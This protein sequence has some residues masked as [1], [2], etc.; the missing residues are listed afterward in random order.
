MIVKQSATVEASADM[1]VLKTYSAQKTTPTNWTRH[2]DIT[3]TGPN[4]WLVS[5][6]K[7]AQAILRSP[8]A[9]QGGFEVDKLEETGQ[10]INTPVLFATGEEHRDQRSKIARF[11]TPATVK[12]NYRP[13]MERV[14]Q[15]LIDDVKTQPTVNL[16]DM[17]M[18]MAVAIAAEV[19]GLTES[20]PDKMKRRI[21]AFTHKPSVP[22]LLQ[23]WEYKLSTYISHLQLAKFYFGD[24]RPAIK[25]RKQSPQADVITHLVEEGYSDV[26]IITEC[27]T[28]AAAGM[29]TTRE[30]LCAAIWHCLEND[31][32]RAIML[33]DDV[34]ARHKLLHEMLRL[35]PVVGQLARRLTTPLQL[36]TKEGE[37]TLPAGAHINIDVY[38]ANSD[39]CTVGAK[40]MALCPQRDIDKMTD[41]V[42]SFGEGAHRC[43][44]AFL[45]IEE[46]DVFIRTLLQVE[47]L[48]MV[49]TP[50]LEWNEVV[51]GYEFRNFMLTAH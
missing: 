13:L 32:L 5:N 3:Q 17:T 46:S 38:A 33:S 45:A 9:T 7:L 20:N 12:K 25:A 43:P 11:F 37:V 21:D 6:A 34:K 48:R 42:L 10:I 30:F 47:N 39:E 19:V 29:V 8:D 40:G 16:S 15:K 24:V 27:V 31:D 51:K 35:E 4:E 2:A 49:G 41:P 23:R 1:P 14:A 26:E 44:G 18:E 22:K 50:D 36:T 28:Y